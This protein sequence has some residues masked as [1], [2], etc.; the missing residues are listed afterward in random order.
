M[1]TIV[2]GAV[3]AAAVL[4]GAGAFLLLQ[5][6]SGK[7]PKLE[8]AQREIWKSDAYNY[9]LEMDADDVIMY[10]YTKDS[11]L[12]FAYGRREPDGLIVVD[13][14][15]RHSLFNLLIWESTPIGR[16][17]D[18]VLRDDLGYE[19]KFQRITELPQVRIN[20]FTKDPEQNFEAFWQ[21]FDEN[22]SL[23]ALNNVDWKA[24]YA[25][26]RPKVTPKTTNEELLGIMTGMIRQL[27]D[28]HTQIIPGLSSESSKPAEDDREKLY[29]DNRKKLKTNIRSYLS[30]EPKSELNDKVLYGQLEG[31]LGYVAF[32]SFMEFDKDAIDA[33]LD[34]LVRDQGNYR[35]IVVD[36]RFN[37][38]GTD[39]F[40]LDAASRF[41]KERALAFSKHARSG[42]YTE[43]YKPTPIYVEPHQNRVQAERVVVLTSRVTASAAEAARMAFG[44]MKHVTI[45]GET[46]NGIHSDMLMNILPNKWLVTL[47]AEQYIAADGKVYEQIGLKPGEEVLLQK[48]DIE[49]G[50]DPVLERAIALLKK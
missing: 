12:P 5:A 30:G 35:G 17:R 25:E 39:V 18:G 44:T 32:D 34:R 27:K 16:F 45:I 2:R 24:L 46:T 33:A 8:A 23:F 19:K 1:K 36:L 14:V 21:I 6:N 20:Q 37:G 7:P 48:A 11:L 28:G 22:Y 15:H 43:F 3:A 47:S 29:A 10:N 41:A 4:L 42:G 13:H 26:N 49:A 40:A 31:N 38:G 50:K 9:I